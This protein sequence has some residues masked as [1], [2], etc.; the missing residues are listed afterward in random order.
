[1][2]SIELAGRQGSSK[3]PMRKL[4]LLPAL[5]AVLA[6][7]S[8]TLLSYLSFIP[9]YYE[10]LVTQCVLEGCGLASP[11]PPTSIASLSEAGLTVSS[12]AMWFVALDSGFT[13]LFAA[14]GFVLLAKGRHE[15]VGLLAAAMFI[16]FGTTF[17]QLIHAAAI[18]HPFWSAWFAVVSWAGWVLLFLFFAIFPNGRFS[19]RWIAVPVMAF[20]LVKLGG[21]LF[22]ET[23]LD[24]SQWPIIPTILLFVLPIG[25]LIYSQ[26]Y[27]YRRGSSH[28]QRQQTKWVVYGLTVSLVAFVA[29]SLM[30]SPGLF[31]SPLAYIYLNGFLHLFLLMIPLTLCMAILRKRLWDV[32][33]IMKR[34][35]VYLAL[36]ASVAAIY[37]L[38]VAYLGALFHTEGYVASLASTMLAAILFAPLKDRLQR[39]VDRLMKGR[40]G[41]PYGLLAELRGLLVKP[42]PPEAMLAAIARL[43]RQALRLPY[44][45]IAIE[46]NG[47]ERLAAA[48]SDGIVATGDVTLPIVHRGMQVGTLVAASRPG[49]PMTGEDRRLLDVLLSHAGP[50]VDNYRMTHGMKLLADDLQRSRERLVLAREEERRVLRRNL[51]DELAPR[52]AALGL[53]ATAAEMQVRR[54]PEA[55]T[56]LLGELRHTIRSTVTDIRAMVRDMRP[57]SLDEWGLIGALQERIREMAAPARAIQPD[58][59][60]AAPAIDFHAPEKLPL[61]PAAVEVAAYWIV[62]EATAN[63]VRHAGASRCAVRLAMTGDGQLSIEVVDDGIGIDER[64]ISGTAGGKR[65]I[66]IGSLRER[67]SELGGSCTIERLADGGTSVKAILPVWTDKQEEGEAH[68]ENRNRG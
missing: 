36:T 65:G 8:V 2:Q 47:I 44:A 32:D 34:S 14:A 49:E 7:G 22:R 26:I 64:W 18:G 23:N 35:I 54:N 37:G 59:G 9:A 27:R 68:V 56:E 28:E 41:D 20:A 11:A 17:P 16:A 19:P 38:S 63:V 21:V 24:H 53:N 42:L 13:L 61:L 52:L 48:D 25:A 62:S 1:M 39:A 45:A 3:R 67:A 51:H 43:V 58:A 30:F 66:G 4:L 31:H 12:Y 60:Y 5:W 40:H 55:A 57:S 15:P 50:I 46:L 33:P 29:I 10:R 6:L